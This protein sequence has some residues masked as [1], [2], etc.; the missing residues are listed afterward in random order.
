MRPLVGLTSSVGPIAH[1]AWRDE[2]V[3]VPVAYLRSLRAAGAEVIV[4]PPGGVDTSVLDA[5]DALVLTGGQDLDPGRYGAER[6]PLTVDVVHEQD[7][8]ELALVLT[9]RARDLPVLGVCRGMQVMAV[10]HG[11]TLHQH[12]PDVP[13]YAEHGA[14]GGEW[15]E[16]L[17]ELDPGSRASEL[18][19]AAL[20]VNSG[21][22]QGVA[23]PGTLTV[24]GRAPDGLPECLEDPSATF[25]LGVQWHPEMV[26]HQSLFDALVEAGHGTSRPA[27]IAQPD[28]PAPLLTTRSK[29]TARVTARHQIRAERA[30]N[31][32]GERA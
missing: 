29:L 32:G 11:G 25:C 18:L 1:D 6:H 10:A 8:T 28:Q 16:H 26:G 17:V 4:L 9:A 2:A 3:H 22:H 5:V 30:L 15:S 13:P 21:H 24:T 27:S 12:L 23:D 14:W 19:G 31:P 7:E 20:T